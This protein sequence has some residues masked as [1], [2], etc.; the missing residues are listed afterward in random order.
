MIWLT[1][2]A[3]ATCLVMTFAL[4]GV[5]MY[6]GFGTFWPVPVVRAYSVDGT[7][8]MGEVTRQES[9]RP[10][11]SVISDLR[12]SV[13][14]F[15]QRSVAA[16]SLAELSDLGLVDPKEMASA[17]ESLGA[18]GS[19]S[20][21]IVEEIT[22]SIM[23]EVQSRLES[24]NGTA[25]RQSIR[26]GNFELTNSH[27]HWLDRFAVAKEDRPQWAMVIER[28]ANGRFYGMPAAFLIDGKEVATDPAIV[29]DKFNE[30][31]DEVR[32][33]WRQRVSLEK[34]DIGRVSRAENRAGWT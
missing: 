29:W 16:H 3:L 20:K 4:I 19:S 30:F 23:G 9:Y 32:R 26:T 28:L 5:I 25:V 24:S 31:H 12:K 34:N 7:V 11:E 6:Y 17:K 14:S 27:F 18:K 10:A 21:K 2:S 15:V 13:M 8:M 1:G 22:D 33:R